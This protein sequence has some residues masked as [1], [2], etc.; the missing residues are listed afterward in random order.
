MV[1]GNN[2]DITMLADSFFFYDKAK[3][4]LEGPVLLSD[5]YHVER[6]S[7]LKRTS[8]GLDNV[9]G[10]DNGGLRSDRNACCSRYGLFAVLS[11]S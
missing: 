9:G 10:G 3:D 7:L 5:I 8:P 11:Y 1:I 2:K 4:R 6:T